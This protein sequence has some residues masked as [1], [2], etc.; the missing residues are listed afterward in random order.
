[1]VLA[2]F[3]AADLVLVGFRHVFDF[4]IIAKYWRVVVKEFAASIFMRD[5]DPL[6]RFEALNPDRPI[7]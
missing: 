4:A 2:L 1:M 7:G 5:F 3:E 6:C